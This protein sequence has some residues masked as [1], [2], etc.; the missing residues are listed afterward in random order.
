VGRTLEEQEAR[1]V[2]E[3]AKRKKKNK[4][5]SKKNSDSP[6]KWVEGDAD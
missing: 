2:R 4:K 6:R 5:V 1:K 3:R